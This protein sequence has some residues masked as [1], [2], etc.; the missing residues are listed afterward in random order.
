ADEAGATAGAALDG[1]IA[2]AQAAASAALTATATP[3]RRVTPQLFAQATASPGRPA[4]VP[5]AAPARES[6]IRTISALALA[7]A[8]RD[9]DA[10]AHNIAADGAAAP[11]PSRLI[12]AASSASALA[13]A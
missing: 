6:S 9:A 2:L 13:I 5:P 12:S 3:A 10:I 8:N 7:M 1:D 4:I 11:A